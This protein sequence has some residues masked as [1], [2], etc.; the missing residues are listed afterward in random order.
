MSGQLL[1]ACYLRAAKCPAA[2]RRACASSCQDKRRPARQHG[3]FC[4]AHAQP[5]QARA[6]RT[7]GAHDDGL[8]DADDS[9]R[10]AVNRGVEQ[11]VC[12]WV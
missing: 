10:A 5:E 9:I 7:L 11:M 2:L 12:A 8:A 4:G 6:K 3:L 1:F